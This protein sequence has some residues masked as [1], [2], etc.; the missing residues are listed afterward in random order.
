MITTTIIVP[1]YNVE[2]F[3]DECIQSILNQ[4]MT[5]IEIIL[6]ND[7][8]TDSSGQKCNEWS[9][10]D[11]RI[12]VIHKKN[13]GLSSSRNVG[14]DHAKGKYISFVDSD[15]IIDLKFVETLVHE[16]KDNV[17]LAVAPINLFFEDGTIKEF[18]KAKELKIHST[19]YI[20][21]ILNHR[22]DN[23]VCN[24]MFIREKIGQ[25]RFKEGII[26]EDFPFM[27]SYLNSISN[28]ALT[29]KHPY[30]YR[31]RTGSITQQ[32]NPKLYDFITNAFDIKSL[33][34]SFFAKDAD[35]Y[36]LYECINFISL[37][38]KYDA[39]NDFKKERSFVLNHVKK[40]KLSLLKGYIGYR[41]VFKL[42]LVLLAPKLF[43]RLAL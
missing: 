5:N 4:S 3:I 27:I 1:V 37:I 13:G 36:I 23:S 39:I 24:K 9:R 29:N 10:H 32:A 16:L 28:V 41:Q 8:S 40:N 19:E 33:L 2:N 7:G 17:E 26:N 6:V 18:Y 21:D 11:N 15:D 22:I 34:P 35:N 20:V 42:S 30:Y 31:Q 25:L 14:L 12:K 38:T 43:R